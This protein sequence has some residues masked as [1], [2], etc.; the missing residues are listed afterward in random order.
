MRA[1]A[2][3]QLAGKFVSLV[4]LFSL[5]APG[6][7]GPLASSAWAAP[8]KQKYADGKA[9][10]AISSMTKG[11]KV[12]IDD[13]LVG[14]VPLPG[15]IEVDANAR[16]TVQVQK[17]G[18]SPYIDT[19]L[20]SSGQ[21]IEVEADLVATGGIVRVT[22]R[23]AA[24][25][26]QLL[27]DGRVAGFTPFDGDVPPGVHTLEARATGYLP[28]T[29]SVDIKAGQEFTY[30]FDLKVVPEPIIKEDK[31]LLSRW[32][33]WTAIGVV[34]VGGVAGGVVGSQDTHVQPKAPDHVLPL[35]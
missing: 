32:W 25:K 16:H 31:S 1:T 11:A 7:A 29:R 20:P 2:R 14:E 9:G 6:I 3:H 8:K 10:I 24:L 19:V 12:L 33:F 5:A 22:S 34:V 35:Q 26:L 30:D 15:P 18:Y 17:R 23:N 13:K 21:V 28:E 4:A 27:V